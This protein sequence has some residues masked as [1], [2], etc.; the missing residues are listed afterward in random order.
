[1]QNTQ[2]GAAIVLIGTNAIAVHIGGS[3]RSALSYVQSLSV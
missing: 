1:M 2:I 3:L